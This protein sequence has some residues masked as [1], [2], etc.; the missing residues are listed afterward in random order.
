MQLSDTWFME[1]YIDY[2]LQQ[3]RL[4]AYLHEVAKCFNET[5]LYPQLADV[6]F[7]YNNMVRFKENKQF[8]Q[9]HFPKKLDSVN[10]QQLELKYEEM[11]ADDD[12]MSELER[13]TVF[14]LKHMK[15]AIASGAEIYEM[16]EQK[17][18]IEPVGILPLYKS[19]GY[20]LLGYSNHTDIRAYA[21]TTT[22]FEHEQAQYRGVRIIYIDSWKR[23]LVNTYEHI[24]RDIIRTVRT[25][26]NPA[27]FRV[28]STLQVPI[29]ETL[30]PIAKR[31]LMR[32]LA[33]A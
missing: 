11:L 4:K 28:E 22:L 19:E 13:I 23:S 2:E 15:N 9:N 32:T 25:L 33:A 8:L 29:D 30:L 18:C 16:V 24:K 21:Y 26:P 17:T 14:A 27:V 12:L 6:V 7:H 5:K 10:L 3:Y 1:G 31:M 20:M